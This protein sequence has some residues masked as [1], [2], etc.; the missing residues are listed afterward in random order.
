MMSR[1][2][3]SPHNPVITEASP[4][5]FQLTGTLDLAT[6]MEFR[7][8]IDERVPFAQNVRLDLSVLDVKG[9]GVLA[10]LTWCLR[11]ASIE[12][13]T[14]IIENPPE[15]LRKIAELADIQGI[16]GLQS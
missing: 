7:Q 6:L 3:S 16:L 8:Q 15:R 4:G 5:V 14:V 9:S 10:L 2:P 13:G 1:D 12:G 11:R